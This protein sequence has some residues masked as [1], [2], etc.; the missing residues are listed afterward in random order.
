[1]LV[2]PGVEEIDEA[3]AGAG[4]LGQPRRSSHHPDA[5]PPQML[6]RRVEIRHRQRAVI[7]MRQPGQPTLTHPVLPLGALPPA[8]T[9][10][11]I[12]REDRAVAQSPTG[13]FCRPAL[14]SPGTK[15]PPAA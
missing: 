10:A 7:D 13:F 5:V 14:H 15:P 3:Q 6:D 12:I 8:V 1:E 2:A 9:G 4:S 11:G